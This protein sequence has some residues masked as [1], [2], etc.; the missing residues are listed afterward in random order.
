VSDKICLVCFIDLQKGRRKF[1]SESCRLFLKKIPKNI[2]CLFCKKVFIKLH[3]S[4]FCSVECRKQNYLSTRIAKEF[5]YH[6]KNKFN[7]SLN[8]YEQLYKNQDGKC[9]ICGSAE[10]MVLQGKVKRIAIDHCHITGVVRGLLCHSC[11]TGLGYFND[12]WVLLDNALE[13][14]TK[15]D[16]KAGINQRWGNRNV[17][18]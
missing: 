7:M 9:A 14:L 13:Y 3:A 4:K 2:E 1:C 16:L 17:N 6:L 15:G 11:N 10:T 8:D 12:N 5:S 18:A